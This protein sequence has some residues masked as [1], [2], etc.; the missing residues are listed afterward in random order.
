MAQSILV[1]EDDGHTRMLLRA[2]LQGSGFNVVLAPNANKALEFLSSRSFDAI[3]IDLILPDISGRDLLSRIRNN[4]RTR[5]VPVLILSVKS[6]E[7]D[8]L[9]A[10]SIGANDYMKK[11]FSPNEVV[12]RLK[13]IIAK[14]AKPP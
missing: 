13:G 11:P 2:K 14:S 1:V 4:P 6:L 9:E 7:D 5:S 8:V 3:V 10:L 12:A